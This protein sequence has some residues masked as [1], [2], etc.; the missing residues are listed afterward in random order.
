MA[1]MDNAVQVCVVVMDACTQCMAGMDNAVQ[2]CVVVV[3]VCTVWQAW[4]TLWR[5]VVCCSCGC[6][7]CM[8][9]WLMRTGVWL[10]SVLYN[11][12]RTLNNNF[13]GVHQKLRELWPCCPDMTF[14]VDWSLKPMI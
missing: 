4:I 13:V 12:K 8:A 2:V 7:Y 1:G 9:T 14:V 11:Y 5:C 3:D 6:V 10:L